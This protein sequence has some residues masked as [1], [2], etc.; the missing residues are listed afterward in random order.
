VDDDPLAL[1]LDRKTGELRAFGPRVE[2]GIAKE[3]FG[4]VGGRVEG[5]LKEIGAITVTEGAPALAGFWWFITKGDDA[6]DAARAIRPRGVSDQVREVGDKVKRW[7]GDFDIKR[8]DDV[9]FVA[10][11]RDGKRRFRMDFDGHG[12]KP[13]GHLEIFDGCRWRDAGGDH[14]LPFLE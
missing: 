6:I 11:S 14:R 10:L 2:G 13:H 12:D 9:G 8:S 3:A 4:Q 5:V 1:A 7:L